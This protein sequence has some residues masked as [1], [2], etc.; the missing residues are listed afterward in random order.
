MSAGIQMLGWVF[1]AAMALLLIVLGVAV[2]LWLEA[3]GYWRRRLRP[4]GSLKPLCRL[5]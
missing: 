4:R 5:G 3:E 2:A 1:G